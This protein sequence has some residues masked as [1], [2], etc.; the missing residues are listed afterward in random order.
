[1]TPTPSL[2]LRPAR[3]EECRALSA[4]IARSLRGLSAGYYAPEE[5]EGALRGA[6]AVDTQLIDD[7]TYFVAEL[8]GVVVGCGGWSFR[9]TLFGGDSTAHRDAGVLD[10]AAAGEPERHPLPGGGTIAFVPMSKD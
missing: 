6:C 9:R 4:L 8:P 1:M 3:R 10:P 2:V 5:V 7:G